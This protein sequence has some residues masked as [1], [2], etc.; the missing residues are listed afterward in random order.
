MKRRKWHSILALGLSLLLVSVALG[1]VPGQSEEYTDAGQKIEIGVGDQFIVAL[2]S[3]PTTGY[4][5]E[6]D[7]DQ[8]FLRLVQDEFE[9]DEAEEGMVGVGGKQRFTFEGLKT[10]ETELTLTYKRSWEEDFADQKVF[11]VSIT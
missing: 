11:V 4:Q 2:E 3:N 1:C 6:A 9:P 5:W 7:F 8:S 10:G